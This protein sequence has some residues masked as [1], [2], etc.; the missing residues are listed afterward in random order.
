MTENRDIDDDE[1]EDT[2]PVIPSN[3]TAVNQ[4]YYSVSLGE[5]IGFTYITSVEWD[6]DALDKFMRASCDIILQAHRHKLVI[7][8]LASGSIT[9][10][11]NLLS[12]GGNNP[13]VDDF[14]E[15]DQGE[16]EPRG[17]S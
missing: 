15:D 5:D 1:K 9:K 7:D 17:Y 14:V 2:E 8:A 12:Y 16:Q 11:K 6:A 4:N 3:F 10:V 13:K